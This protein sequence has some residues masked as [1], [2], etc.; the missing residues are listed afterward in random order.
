MR[1]PLTP[2]ATTVASGDAPR[3]V[4][5]LRMVAVCLALVAVAFLQEPGQMVADTKVDLAVD[6]AGWLGRALYVWDPAGTFGQLQN[7]AYGYLWP[8]GSFFLAGK[9]LAIPAWVVQRL[10][11]AVVM[12]VA[13]TG[14]VKL[15]EKLGIGTPWARII[16]GVAFA[17]SPRLITELGPISVEAWPSALA[18]WVLVPLIGLRQGVPVRRA[19]AR[20]ALAVAC[21]GGVNATAVL[22]VVPLAAIWLC[23]LRPARL[24]FTALAAWGAAVACATAWWLVPLLVLGRFSPPFLDY[25]ETAEVT[26]APTDTVSVL[27][28]ASHWHAYLSTPFG[29]EWP[30]GWHLATQ[31]PLIVATLV[32]AALGVAGLSRRGI[33]HGWFLITGLLT[34]LALVGLGHL[35]AVDGFLAEAQ[36]AFLDG[37][38]APLRNVHKFDVVLRLPLILGL[39]HLLGLAM[40]AAA[41]AGGAAR[42]PARTRAGAVTSVALVA[43]AA[44]ASPALAGGLAPPGSFRAV[45]PYWKQA[46]TWLDQHLDNEHVLV[47]PGTRFPDY[48]WGSPGDEITQ[49]LL[50]SRWGVRNAIPLTPPATIRLL[51]AIEGVLSSGAGSPGLAD[52]LA[53]SG[54]RYLLV[55]SDLDYGR[56]GAT[57]PVVVRQALSRSPGLR[58]VVAFGPP[59][60]GTHPPGLFIDQGLNAAAP[61]LEVWQVDRVVRPVT[62][63]DAAGLTT[64]VG[65]PESILAT[66]AAGE[67]PA[68]PTVLA[69][70]RPADL[71]PGP[72]VLTDGMRRRETAFGMARDRE[73]ATM[74]A[75]EQGRLGAPVRDYLPAWGDDADT[76]VRYRGI[77][78]VSASSSL[79][80]ADALSGSRPAH[81]PYAALDSDTA[82]SWRSGL[83]FASA[84]QWLQVELPAPRVIR[85]VRLTFDLATDSAP[86]RIT[87][88]SGR[89]PPVS[90]DVFSTDM[91]VTLPGAYPTDTVR[92]TF[93]SV[94]DVRL[95]QGGVGLAELVLPGITAD[96]S[97]VVPP[98]PVT[99]GAPA[100]VFSAAP[101]VPACYFDAG[102]PVCS[103]G[104]AR[105]SEDGTRIDRTATVPQ[106]SGYDV[107]VR[108]RARPGAALNDLLDAGGA[109]A[110]TE[111]FA[112][113]VTASSVGVPEPAARPGAVVDGDVGTVW[114]ASGEDRHPWLRLTWPAAQEVSGLR[115]QLP[116]AVAASRV[117]RVTVLGDGDMREGSLDGSGTLLFDRPMTTDEITVLIADTVP[118]RSYDPYRDTRQTLPVAVG[119]IIA[120]PDG[121]AVRVAPDAKLTLPCGSGPA[122]TVDGV[123]RRTALLASRRDLIEMR[124][125]EAVPC[126]RGAAEPLRVLAGETRVVAAASTLA[127]PVRVS[128]APQPG[129]TAGRGGGVPATAND[130]ETPVRVVSWA[131]TLRR[132]HLD[133][134]PGRRVLTLRENTNPGWQAELRGKTLR[135]L[136]IDGWQQGWLV[137]PG[138]DGD[139]VL[140]FAPDRTYTVAIGAGALLVAGLA[141]AAVLPVRR[142]AGTAPAPAVNGRRRWL[143]ATVAG[144]VALLVFGGVTAVGLALLGTAAAVLL[145]ALWPHLGEDDRRRLRL[146]RYWSRFLLPVALLVPAGW[147][148]LTAG[149][150][151]AALPQLTAVGTA[152]ALWLSVALGGGPERR[153]P[154]RRKGRSTT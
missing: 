48:L 52:L 91:T 23:G 68:G 90:R 131:P 41:T 63:Y 53:R 83:G 2:P 95:G 75:G 42:R 39:A 154:S 21:A 86:S 60:G 14:V 113:R 59:V 29:P 1:Q 44:V 36:R 33:P 103:S 107:T 85:E 98:S 78:A 43:V 28:G 108:A 99:A 45:P 18:P 4:W 147:F 124:E 15:A 72:V 139:V 6:P 105:G 37:A 56:S 34:G 84:G 121:P 65:G 133:A 143:L 136:V 153:W 54:V 104:L 10:W 150:H 74:Q 125:V 24:R 123:S 122:V 38:G 141:V 135:P 25:I 80:N 116:E 61:A 115:V 70:D 13:F 148:A 76:V 66:A 137:P 149:G 145:R 130:R 87:V 35:G 112:P 127:V 32:V 40:R 3:A 100:M 120:L 94:I 8:M 111:G 20:S 5:R 93:D 81:Q 55:R 16:A 119:E 26:T 22:A 7:Q 30:A 97:L 77:R 67:L 128:L 118:A 73:S 69:G 134:Y 101:A 109:A 132:L 140:S 129:S 19:V 88:T 89:N 46:A 151:T 11:W 9:L 31:R 126:G 57:Q 47:V 79:A 82:T 62:A 142:R 117:L 138:A 49:P 152:V 71:A 50:H 64:V 146:L 58:P 106:T 114:H 17:L 27:R 110:V 92:V 144:G 96:R 12:T 102:R 51:D